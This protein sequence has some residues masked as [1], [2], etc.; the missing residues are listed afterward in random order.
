MSSNCCSRGKVIWSPLDSAAS[1]TVTR[2]R[3]WAWITG[4]SPGN[5]SVALMSGRGVDAA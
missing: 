5:D 1:A 3:A 4:S 2:N